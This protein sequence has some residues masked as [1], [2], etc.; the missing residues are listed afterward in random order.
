MK[1]FRIV[2]N[3]SVYID[4]YEDGEQD[5]VNGYE[6]E[7]TIKAETKEEAINKYFSDFLYFNLSIENC[8]ASEDGYLQTSCL[9]DEENIQPTSKEI[10]LWKENKLK[11]YVNHIDLKVYELVEVKF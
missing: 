5:Y 4:N 1:Q 2:S 3:H 11:L 7:N 8:E 9:L 10:E 6:L